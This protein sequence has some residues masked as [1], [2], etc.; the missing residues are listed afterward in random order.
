MADA[1]SQS[2]QMASCAGGADASDGHLGVWLCMRRLPQRAGF[3]VKWAG[4][5]GLLP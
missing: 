1:C 3:T 4:L 2:L 5:Q